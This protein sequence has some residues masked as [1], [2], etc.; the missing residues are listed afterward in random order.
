MVSEEIVG[1]ELG[2]HP[3][4]GEGQSRSDHRHRR[5]RAVQHAQQIGQQARHSQADEHERDGQLLG[6]V[7]RATR[8]RRQSRS[9]HTYDDG[10]HR[11]ILVPSG[12]LAEHSL[13]E[14]HQHQQAG[15][16][17]RLHDDQ[18][19]QPE[20]DHL[21][22]PSEDR[23]PRA[24]QPARPPDQSPHERQAQVLLVRRL[25]GVGCLERDP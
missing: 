24:E 25:L 14:E 11:Q 22:R 16:E 1:G 15:G 20:R 21:Q 12:V 3:A 10:A 8:G 7:R 9:D 5:G 6:G 4:P 23:Q 13:G 18:R 17:R 2:R 19:S